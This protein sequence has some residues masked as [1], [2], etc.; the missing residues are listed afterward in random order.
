MKGCLKELRRLKRFFNKAYKEFPDAYN[1]GVSD[2]L[3]M[4]IDI[5]K[6]KKFYGD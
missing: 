6:N 5:L 3:D 2:G 4:A 1:A